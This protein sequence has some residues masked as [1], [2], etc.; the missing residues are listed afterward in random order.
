MSSR[1]HSTRSWFPT[2]SKTSSWPDRS[3]AEA[4][5][6]TLQL[7]SVIGR[8]FTGV[9]DRLAEIQN[10]L[11][12]FCESSRR[13]SLSMRRVFPESLYVQARA[14]PRCGVQLSSVPA[15]EELH[16]VIGLA[17]EEFS[18]ERLPSTMKSSS[19]TS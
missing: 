6:K 1:S 3:L 11:R 5:K 15:T 8:E 14:H 19:I 16:R 18:M 9:V 7:A 12:N 10:G 13:L 17:I 4:P 2:R